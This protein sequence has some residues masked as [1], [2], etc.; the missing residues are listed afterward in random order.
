MGALQ[1]R[2]AWDEAHVSCSRTLHADAGHATTLAASSAAS[3][4]GGV[5][6]AG[7]GAD[8]VLTLWSARSDAGDAARSRR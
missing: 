6:G 5:A 2:A 1:L 4:A 3:D 7:E 8:A